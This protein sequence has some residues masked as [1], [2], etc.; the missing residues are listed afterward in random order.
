MYMFA[1]KLINFFYLNLTST[2]FFI[3]QPK[4]NCVTL[5]KWS[6]HSYFC[7]YEIGYLCAQSDSQLFIQA[8]LGPF[9]DHSQVG[10]PVC[11]KQR[12]VVKTFVFSCFS[13]KQ[14]LYGHYLATRF[15]L[16]VTKK[17][18][19]DAAQ[20]FLQRLIPLFIETVVFPIECRNTNSNNM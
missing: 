12:K 8:S 14:K 15:F 1:V 7:N 20:Q 19:A 4:C 16:L 17:M 10:L 5:K 6:L 9:C 3:Y 13:V 11:F 2:K 18:H